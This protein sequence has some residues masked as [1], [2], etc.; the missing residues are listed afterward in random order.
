MQHAGVEVQVPLGC[1]RIACKVHSHCSALLHPIPRQLLRSALQQARNQCA[2]PRQRSAQAHARHEAQRKAS[3]ETGANDASDDESFQAA[4]DESRELDKRVHSVDTLQSLKHELQV[5]GDRLVVLEVMAE[6][7]CDTGLFEVDDGWSPDQV[8]KQQQKLAAC[9]G[10]RHAA[11]RMAA[12][13]PNVRFLEYVVR[14][15]ALTLMLLLVLSMRLCTSANFALG[16]T[17]HTCKTFCVIH[18]PIVLAVSMTVNNMLP[19]LVCVPVQRRLWWPAQAAMSAVH[20]HR[21]QCCLHSSLPPVSNAATQRRR[22]RTASRSSASTTKW[23]SSPQ[24]S[25]SAAAS[26]SGACPAPRR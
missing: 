1:F 20:M 19:F 14:A 26:S 7:I 9:D 17:W 3:P 8:D 23:T 12:D 15:A 22:T 5:A 13:S 18:A 24:C 2:G 16:Y 4:L 25:S 21:A 11:V 6:G 10:I